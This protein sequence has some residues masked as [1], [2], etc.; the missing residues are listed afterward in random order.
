MSIHRLAFHFLRQDVVAAFQHDL[1]HVLA[2]DAFR[3]LAHIVQRQS[4]HTL[5]FYE[6]PYR[7]LKFLD[8]ALAVYGDRPAAVANELTKLFEN[9][10]RG[11]LSELR[12]WF[13]EHPPRGEYTVVIAGAGVDAPPWE[14][15]DAAE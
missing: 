14:M 4:P 15:P 3:H 8:D 12:A 11:R 13:A 1:R 5:V 10:Q 2:A 6:S 9:V 7:L